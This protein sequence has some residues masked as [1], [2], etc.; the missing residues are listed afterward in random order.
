MQWIGREVEVKNL[1]RMYRGVLC[2]TPKAAVNIW[3]KLG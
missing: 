3:V 1:A 2:E